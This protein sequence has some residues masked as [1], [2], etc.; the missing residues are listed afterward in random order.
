MPKLKFN[1]YCLAITVLLA[2]C[3]GY[4]HH[5]AIVGPHAPAF[6]SNKGFAGFQVFNIAAGSGDDLAHEQIGLISA[7]IPLGHDGHFSLAVMQPVSHTDKVNAEDTVLTLRYQRTFEH[8]QE[9]WGGDANFFTLVFGAEVPTGNADGQTPF[10]GPLDTLLAGFVSVEK[11]D[12]SAIAYAYRRFNGYTRDG[13][14]SGDLF[15]AG[16]G[17][18]YSAWEEH[19]SHQSISLQ[20]G[21]SFEHKGKTT[22][23][24]LDTNLGMDLPGSDG[25][26]LVAHPTIAYSMSHHWDMFLTFGFPLVQDY[27][28]EAEALNWRAGLG[29]IYTFGDDHHAQNA[30]TI[31]GHGHNSHH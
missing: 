15:Y 24:N 7:G 3:T 9:E 16:T 11:G 30:P 5:E 2:P 13:T 4:S 8:L 10:K 27:Q 21:I 23:H 29:F 26:S 12:W 22:L 1:A 28:D 6:F 31:H 14:K 20:A 25:W 18:G 17:I 19:S